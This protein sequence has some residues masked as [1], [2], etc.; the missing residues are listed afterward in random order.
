MN[1]SQERTNTQLFAIEDIHP[2]K[3]GQQITLQARLQTSR[4]PSAKLVFLTFRQNLNCVQATL[5]MAPEKVSRQMTK[6]AAA[7]T[8]ESI[9]QVEGTISK[10]PK[11]IESS[12]V[13]VKDAEI[14]ICLLY[15][16]DAADE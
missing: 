2:D 4:A 3:D 16:S 11:P 8:P 9:V 10:V 5:A 7:I 12:S 15:T 6:W 13:T 1:Q 14:K